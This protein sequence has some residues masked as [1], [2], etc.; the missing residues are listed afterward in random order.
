M[1]K[2]GF[3]EK[4]AD[5]SE[6]AKENSNDWSEEDLRIALAKSQALEELGYEEENISWEATLENQKRTDVHVKDDVGGFVAVFECKKPSVD[7]TANEHERQLRER[8]V[9]PYKV[10]YGILYNGIEL[11]FYKR[12][13]HS[14]D[15]VFRVSADEL[16]DQQLNQLVSALHKPDRS[17]TD[18]D[19][20]TTYMDKYRDE[21][22]RLMLTDDVAREYFY[23]NFQLDEDSVFGRLVVNT[24]KLFEDRHGKSDFLE[25]AYQF[26]KRSYAKELNKKQIPDEWKP[27]FKQAG[28]SAGK[29]EDR[30]KFTFCLETSYALFTRLILTKSAEDYDFPGAGFSDILRRQLEGAA[31]EGQIPQPGYGN[32]S[33]KIIRDMEAKLISSVF[34][35]DI[36]YWWTEPYDARDDYIAYFRERTAPT[37]EVTRFGK[38]IAEILLTV[39]KYDF[40]SVE[41]ED[42]LGVL[43]QRYFDKQ[44]RKALGEFYT[45]K[46]VVNYILDSVGY[47]GDSVLSERILDPACGSGTFLVEALDRYLTAAEESGKADQVGWRSVLQDLVNEYHILGFDIHPFAT[48]M[49]QIQFTLKLL[50]YYRKAI[51]EE[52]GYFV[53]KR[54]PILRT[55]SLEKERHSGNLSLEDSMRGRILSMPIELPITGEAEEDFFEEDFKLPFYETVR[56]N[57]S[58]TN[59]QQYFGA[60]QAMFDAV[61]ERAEELEPDTEPEIERDRLAVAFRDAQYLRNMEWD[62]L[63]S[64]F[65]QDADLLLKRIKQLKH[66]FDDGRLVKSI[67]DVMLAAI[68]K[69]EMEYEYV[70]G[71]PPYVRIQDL[72]DKQ[73]NKWSDAYD[74][75]EGN[76]DIY[77]PFIERGIDW[78]KPEGRLSYITSNRFLLTNYGEPM[79]EQLPQD[80]TID[81]MVDMRDSRVFKDALNYPAIFVFSKRDHPRGYFPVSRVFSDPDS[82][83][84]LLDDIEAQ[85]NNLEDEEDY[86]GGDHSDAFYVSYEG[87]SPNG[88][89][90]MPPDEQQIFDKLQAEGEKLSGFTGTGS[91][92]FQGVST[93]KDDVYVLRIIGESGQDYRVV[94]KG[95]GEPFNIEKD[96]VRPFLFGKDIQRWNIEWKNWVVIFPY[97]E[98]DDEMKLIPSEEYRGDYGY[99]DETIE[100]LFPKTWS[101][102]KENETVLRGRDRGQ[103]EIGESQAHKW[104]GLAY[105]RSINC[106]DKEKLLVQVSSDEADIA[107]DSDGEFVFTGGG[108][109]GA[110]GILPE[111]IPSR[112]LAAL[113]NSA[114]L[115]FFLKHIS[116]VYAGKSYSY[117]DQF[118]KQLPIKNDDDL[119]GEISSKAEALSG[120]ED[121]KTRIELF[122]V[123][124]FNDLKEEGTVHEWDEVAHITKRG[125][126]PLNVNRQQDL[127]GNERIELG[128]DDVIESHKIDSDVKQEYVITAI[129]GKRFSKEE[130]IV[131]PL[132][133]TDTA[134]Q[135][136]LEMLQEDKETLEDGQTKEEL[137]EELNALVFDLYGIDDDHQQVIQRFLGRF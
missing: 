95:G 4:L 19:S 120:R 92:G 90:L 1:S 44:T 56:D 33:L 103:F 72:P 55:D 10:D 35:E 96:A 45:P 26:W 14:M 128:K 40:S 76:Y 99:G 107:F 9:L 74:Y 127:E 81:K 137:E 38:S 85:I 73:K 22:D 115:D 17:T 57:T 106:Y 50:P 101:Y 83:Q 53:L 93:S 34:E 126:Y 132:P 5:I 21:A 13:G 117:G 11:I 129:D 36:F 118:L 52:D 135:K 43:Y 131:I 8:Y 64:Y 100:T 63:A 51:Q 60:I 113:I 136:A 12:Q 71:N 79:R 27:L 108:T 61:K 130:Q 82:G 59:T 49:A 109:S 58:I 29:K 46:E 84:E 75:A 104:Y 89:F 112:Y 70:V 94:P 87:I 114:S 47:E 15:R 125:Y 102:L 2:Q 16:D 48:I 116:T 133:R 20:V 91:G 66:E 80:A 98:Y 30:F 3:A 123:P 7:I 122:P 25:S 111:G 67:E 24:I 39:Y 37:E 88:W 97:K 42:I 28:I 62:S 41:E 32:M 110:Y 54:L 31:W 18:L 65:K 121:L 68:L 69:N 124:H 134:A 119:A 78:L 77:I 23:E 86:S 105:P 6:R